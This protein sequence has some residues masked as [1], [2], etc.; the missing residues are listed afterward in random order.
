MPELKNGDG[1]EIRILF[2]GTAEKTFV[3]TIVDKY[4]NEVPLHTYTIDELRNWNPEV[5]FETR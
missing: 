5:S 4:S 3:C 1:E 2:E